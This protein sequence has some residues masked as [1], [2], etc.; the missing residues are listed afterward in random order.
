MT[1]TSDELKLMIADMLLEL[2]ELRL[3]SR[4]QEAFT[5]QV[6]AEL[7]RLKQPEES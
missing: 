2:H 6:V 7:E 4:E 5:K 1:L 3:R